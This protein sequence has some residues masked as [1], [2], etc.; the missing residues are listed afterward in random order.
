VG[1]PV[2]GLFAGAVTLVVV[3]AADTVRAIAGA[4]TGVLTIK[5]ATLEFIEI[6]DV[7]LLATVLYIMALGLYELFIDDSLPLPAW[8]EIRTLDDLK[9]KLVGVVVVVMA[10]LFLGS[11]IGGGDAEALMMRGVGIAAV[12]AALG[13]FL[14]RKGTH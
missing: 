14:G 6:A 2:V 3:A 10:V 8:L 1:L 5:N 13:Y 4:F 7:F 11:V 9:D 12:I